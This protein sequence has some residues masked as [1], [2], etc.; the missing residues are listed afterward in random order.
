MED[1][2]GEEFK[3]RRQLSQWGRVKVAMASA[4]GPGDCDTL[5]FQ[6]GAEM[7]RQEQTEWFEEQWEEGW[8]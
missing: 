8:I 3:E 2:Q 4:D 1:I 5:G 6:A 7:V